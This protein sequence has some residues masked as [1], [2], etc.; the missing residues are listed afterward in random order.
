MFSYALI[1]LICLIILKNVNGIGIE[2]DMTI[3]G[4]VYCN[5][6]LVDKSVKARLQGALIEVWE[7]YVC[8]N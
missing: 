8:D 6:H 1:I 2:I 4:T 3:H 7:G 5:F